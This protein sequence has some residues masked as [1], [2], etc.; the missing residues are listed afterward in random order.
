MVTSAQHRR[1]AT[2]LA[3]RY[4]FRLYRKRRHLIWR[5]DAGAQV[6]CAATPSCHHALRN[7]EARLRRYA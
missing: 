6:T 1:A 4:G 3:K 5:N 2:A 7:F